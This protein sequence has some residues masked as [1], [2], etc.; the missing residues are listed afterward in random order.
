MNLPNFLISGMPRCGTTV[1]HDVLGSHPDIFLSPGHSKRS[2]R[3]IWFYNNTA[4]EKKG[5][6]WYQKFFEGASGE[7]YVGEKTPLYMRETCLERIRRDLGPDVKFLMCVRNPAFRAHSHW[8]HA[9]MHKYGE[10]YTKFSFGRCIRDRDLNYSFIERSSYGKAVKAF[11][12]FYDKDNL[13]VLVNEE[14]RANPRKEYAKLFNWL[15]VDDKW[16]GYDAGKII[17]PSDY[18]KYGDISQE[19]FSFL[20]DCLKYDIEDFYNFLG[21]EVEAWK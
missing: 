1:A 3:E 10:K 15:G 17:N 5:Y 11:L 2:N 9:N 12:K 14:V 4:Y 13:Y 20:K 21:R 6:E 7:K 16:D 19:D 8:V 18:K